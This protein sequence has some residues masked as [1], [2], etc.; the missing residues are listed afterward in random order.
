VRKYGLTIDS[1]LAAEVVTADGRILP[2]SEEENPDLFWAV[3]GGGGNCG[4][5]TRFEFS[6]APVTDVVAGS[7]VY[8]LEDLPQLVKGWREVMRVAPDELSSA[9][10]VMPA[11]AGNPPAATVFCCYAGADEATAMGVIEPLLRLGT[12]VQ[13]E[14]VT[15]AYPDVLE[16]PHPPEGI[17]VVVKSVFVRSLDDDLVQTI[18]EIYGSGEARVLFLRSLG[19]AMARVPANATAFGHR[20]VETMLVS[21]T[22]MA[23]DAS[24]ADTEQAL[25]PWQRVAAFGC[26]SYVNFLSTATPED[27]AAIYPPATYERLARVKQEFDPNNVFSQNHNVRMPG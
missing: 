5:V 6:A 26:G 10:V 16:D 13:H 21:G 22:F 14:I 11:F 25:Q 19:G 8:A 12:V 4:V 7:I 27:V 2:A 15:K 9:F 17:R 20:D 3:R 23:P 18:G 24:D 1:M